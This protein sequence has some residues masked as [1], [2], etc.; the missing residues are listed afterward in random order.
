MKESKN[1]ERLYLELGEWLDEA[2]HFFMH[3]VDNHA[4]PLALITEDPDLLLDDFVYFC[5]TKSCRTFRAILLLIDQRFEEDALVLVRS[6][7]EN[8][9]SSAYAIETPAALE[10]FVYNRIGLGVGVLEHP[11]TPKGKRDTRK[12]RNKHTDEISSLTLTIADLSKGTGVRED[13]EFFTA[14]YN[15]LCQHTH[16]NMISSGSYRTDDNSKYTHCC[17]DAPLQGRYYTTLV[18]A[19]YGQGLLKFSHF[20]EELKEALML[21]TKWAKELLLREVDTFDFTTVEGL[22]TA[23]PHRLNAFET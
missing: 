21:L 23:I 16:A 13:R 15:Y 14:F 1:L 4:K 11:L 5:V 17:H 10:Y 6:I 3:I 9:L 20:P 22:K 12:V 8:Y 19:L 7:Y 18:M 2:V